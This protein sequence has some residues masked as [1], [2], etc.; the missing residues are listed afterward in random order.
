VHAYDTCV[1]PPPPR[2]HPT[3]PPHTPCSLTSRRCVVFFFG[4]YSVVQDSTRRDYQQAMMDMHHANK[5][6]QVCAKRALWVSVS[7]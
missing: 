5:R 2:A 3:Y 4:I 6:R 1:R 7:E